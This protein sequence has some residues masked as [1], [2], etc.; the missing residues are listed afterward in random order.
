MTVFELLSE[1]LEPATLDET[2]GETLERAL[3]RGHQHVA[4]VD[5]AGRLIATVRL[6]DLVACPNPQTPL[7]EFRLQTPLFIAS[8]AH[9]FDAVEFVVDN[10]VDVLPVVD[11]EGRYLGALDLTGL[12]RS[13]S[14][15][16]GIGEAG[17]IIEIDVS[18]RDYALGRLVHTIEEHGARVLSVNSEQ[19][20]EAGADVRLTVKMSV[21]DTVRIRA[22][23]E[24]YGYSVVA[25]ERR[26]SMAEDLQQRVR[27]FIHY[28]DV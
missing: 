26:Q 9:L 28:L 8:E 17:S 22:V 25:V 13:V 5:A 12:L 4:V 20:R 21:S 24:H 2:V 16:L 23:L 10:E 15:A 7:R 3:E 1:Y 18:P 14:R 6:P 19:P 11:A 27:E